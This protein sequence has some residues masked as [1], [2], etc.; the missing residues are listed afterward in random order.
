VAR[1]QPRGQRREWFED[2]RASERRMQ[3]SWHP[4]QDLVVL[5]LW[6]GAV[7]T[8]TFR[9]PIKDGPRLIELLASGMVA[10]VADTA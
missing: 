5:S 6:S 2:E 8:A 7:C 9:L 10:S 3:V 1:Q 4:E